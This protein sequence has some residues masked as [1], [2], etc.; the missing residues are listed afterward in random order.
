MSSKKQPNSFVF[1]AIMCV[2][3]SLLLT[4]TA[5]GLK[6]RQERNVLLDQQ[7]NVLKAL[8]L[9]DGQTKPTAE[10]IETLYKTNV[11]ELSMTAE[12]K[13]TQ[14]GVTDKTIYAVKQN[15]TL[16]KYA[17]P[18]KAYGLWSWVYGYIAFAGNGNTIIG[19]TVFQHAETPGLG[20]E[21][22]KPWFQNQFVGKTITDQNGKFVS[23]GIAK[24]KASDSVSDEKLANYVDGMS[25]ATITSKGMEKY[26]KLEIEKY[27][28]FAKRLRLGS[29]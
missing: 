5:V 18:F 14:K 1:A 6:P 19:L 9:I 24:G 28:P 27:E 20:G 22:E 4:G 21:V 3:F 10:T 15:D 7:K 2:V 25:G 23:V 29:N 26:L 8:G 11:L 16:T 17:L 12:G 13:L